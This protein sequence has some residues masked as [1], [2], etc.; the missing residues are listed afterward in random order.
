MGPQT[1]AADQLHAMKYRGKGE[2]YREAM[3]RVAFGLKDDDAHYHVFREVLLDMRF[4]PGGRIQNAIGGTRQTTPYNCYYSGVIADSSAD[5]FDKV[6]EAFLTMR[7]GGGIGFDFSSLRPKGDQI[8]S[9]GSQS[10]G[11]LSFMRIFNET[12]LC[13]ASAGHRRGAM[14]AVMRV[15]HPDILEFVRAKH[16][17]TEYRGFNISVGITDAFMEAV[18]AGKDFALNFGGREY[19]SIDAAELWNVIMRS[20][21]DYSE[22]G[23]MFLDRINQMNNLWYAETITGTNPCGEVPLPPY[24]ACL[25]GSFNL[26]KYLRAVHAGGAGDAGWYFDFAQLQTDI[27]AVVRAMDNVVDRARY[28]LAEQ[29][30]E[31]ISKRRMGLGVT[32]LANAGEACGLAYGSDAFLDFTAD[33]LRTIRDAAYRA[34]AELA[35][36]KDSFPLYDPVRFGQSKFIATLPED[37]RALIAANG[38][39]NSHLLSIAPTGTISMCADNVSSGIE[40]VF[41]YQSRRLINT[42]DGPR[43]SLIDDYGSAVLGVKGKRA[44]TVSAQDHVAVLT[45]AQRFVDQAVSKTVNMDS[46]VMPWSDFVGLYS[47]AFQGGA[48]GCTTFNKS[49]KR[50]GIMTDAEDGAACTVDPQTGR[51]E[52]A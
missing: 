42:P 17:D 45:T 48:K 40:P 46:A 10:S 27:P 29:K 39:R 6:K 4:M 16:N 32:G 37:I 38:I 22:P 13:A 52:C 28:P 18:Y 19:N 3:N 43:E 9:L 7:M 21:W 25:L 1:A 8:R 35:K 15:D 11:P 5:I 20:T 12:G 14:M 31:A 44:D 30:A 26:V 33:V 47:Q 36:E 49:G 24:G 34:S 51:R 23:V 2:D 41:A 50:A